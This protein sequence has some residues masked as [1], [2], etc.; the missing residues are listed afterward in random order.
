MKCCHRWFS[1]FPLNCRASALASLIPNTRPADTQRVLLWKRVAQANRLQGDPDSH[2]H[3]LD[4]HLQ[5]RSHHRGHSHPQAHSHHRGR[6]HHHDLGNHPQAHSRRRGHSH[7]RVN[8]AEKKA[9]P[10]LVVQR[11]R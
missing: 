11:N 4:N 3:D 6:S 9:G 1:R 8:R 10:C 2:L 5:A 7:L